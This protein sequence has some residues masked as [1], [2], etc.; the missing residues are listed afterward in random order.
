MNTQIFEGAGPLGGLPKHWVKYLTER[1]GKGYGGNDQAGE[2]SVVTPLKRFDGG[3]IS[4]AL[5]DPNNLAVIGR[6]DG[7]PL[8]MLTK[9]DN[10]QTKYRVF[11]V[12]PSKGRYEAKG[13]TFYTGRHGASR[14]KT[15]DAYTMSQVIDIADQLFSQ[16]SDQ[17][18]TAEAISKD[19]ERAGKI[20]TRRE[21]RN[22]V[23]PLYQEKPSYQGA[24]APASAAQH[25]R[26]KKWADKKLPILDAKMEEEVK[27]MK[28]KIN[29][30]LD[31]ALDKALADVKRG[32]SY[33]LD[34]ASLG[35]AILAQ[36]DINPILKLAKGYD[37]I[38]HNWHNDPLYQKAK[39]LKNTG[40]IP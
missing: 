34:K 7:E 25:E 4:R 31:D 8:F 30:V 27:K 29:A 32:Y 37:T 20:E 21:I 39:T 11:E 33:S 14:S 12:T 23:D 18:L 1:Y 13:D 17:E 28:D 5:K 22:L 24:Y 19:P 16:Y 38:K 6:I 15:Q 3:N 26:A 10:F 40:L 2:K 36:V 35:K 9:H